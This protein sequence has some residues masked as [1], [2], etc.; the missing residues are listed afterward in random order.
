MRSNLIARLILV[1]LLVPAALCQGDSNEADDFDYFDN[2]DD[3]ME[4]DPWQLDNKEGEDKY[5]LL[6]DLARQTSRASN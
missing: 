5:V 4:N 3:D 2:D 1:T 6:F